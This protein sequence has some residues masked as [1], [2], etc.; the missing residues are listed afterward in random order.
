M[1]S[2]AEAY[3]PYS[4]N[5]QTASARAMM[6]VAE[7]AGTSLKTALDEVRLTQRGLSPSAMDKIKKLGVAAGDL[8]WIIKPRTLAHRKSKKELLT[9]DETG[10]WLRAA[11]VQALALEVFGDQHKALNWLNKPRQRFGNQ[12]AI[13]MV[14]SEPGAQLVE[15]TLNQL[16]AGYFA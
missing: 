10:R 9:P 2:I 14:K 8:H 5:Q 15:E 13:E 7:L 6:A 1:S 3:T 4:A 16:D 12:P 11:K